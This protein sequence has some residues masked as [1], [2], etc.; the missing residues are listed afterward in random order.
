MLCVRA[1]RALIEPCW[2]V[3]AG[4]WVR[5]ACTDPNKRGAPTLSKISFK[6]RASILGLRAFKSEL[7]RACQ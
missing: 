2:W 3:G 4:W 1:Q 7:G 6:F 5:D